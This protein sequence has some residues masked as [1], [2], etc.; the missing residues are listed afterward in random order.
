MG[1]SSLTSVVEDEREQNDNRDRHPKHPEQNGF[2]HDN[3]L[4]KIVVAVRLRPCP[5]LRNI[6][7]AAFP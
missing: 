4:L 2:T 5:I 6:V 7:C 3:L 1:L